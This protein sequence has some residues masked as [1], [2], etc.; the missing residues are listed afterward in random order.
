MCLLQL[1]RLFVFILRRFFDWV[2]LEVGSNNFYILFYATFCNILT[3][4]GGK[5]TGG[6]AGPGKI[7]PNGHSN[8]KEEKRRRENLRG[9]FPSFHFDVLQHDEAKQDA[10]NGAT[11]MSYHA[12]AGTRGTCIRVSSVGGMAKVKGKE[13]EEPGQLQSPRQLTTARMGCLVPAK[14]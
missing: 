11:R 9:L 2:V 12:D 5:D 8:Q 1:L 10:S 6:S 4:L 7:H 3:M 13:A 14:P